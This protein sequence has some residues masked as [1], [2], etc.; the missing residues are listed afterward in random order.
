[1]L[2]AF[3]DLY[4]KILVGNAKEEGNKMRYYLGILASGGAAGG[5]NVFLLY[6]FEYINFRWYHQQ[7]QKKS[8]LTAL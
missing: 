6:P 4:Q 5:T 2:F 1:M 8:G 7:H 3:K